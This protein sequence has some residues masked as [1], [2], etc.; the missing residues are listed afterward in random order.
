MTNSGEYGARGVLGIGT[1][2]ANP[3]VEPEVSSLMPGGVNLQATRLTS[4]VQDS[5]DR[6][7]DYIENLGQAPRTFD[8]LRLDAFGFGC[9]GSSY[10]IGAAREAEIVAAAEQEFGY[11]IITSALAVCAGLEHLGVRRVALASPYPDWLEE[12]AIAYWEAAGFEIVDT[13]RIETGQA[14]TRGIYGVTSAQAMERLAALD[15]SAADGVLLAGTGMPTLGVLGDIESQTGLPAVSSNFCLAWA[16]L[17][18]VDLAPNLA[19]E[20]LLSGW[21]ARFRARLG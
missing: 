20:T 1:P 12:A 21:Q 5:R 3:T 11:P 16:M 2:Q 13:V 6:L 14:D 4:P 8:V 17:R 15:V 7:I 10:L 18:I 19:D 9:T